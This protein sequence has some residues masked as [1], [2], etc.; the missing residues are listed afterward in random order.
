MTEKHRCVD[1]SF[2]EKAG[3]IITGRRAECGLARELPE[4]LGVSVRRERTDTCDVPRHYFI[5][6]RVV[7]T[8]GTAFEPRSGVIFDGTCRLLPDELKDQSAQQ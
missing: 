8:I 1:C 4:E 5:A 3:N 7:D 2:L 6:G